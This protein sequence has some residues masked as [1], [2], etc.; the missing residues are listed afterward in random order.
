[1]GVGTK[2]ISSLSLAATGPAT[3]FSVQ[4]K[5][6]IISNRFMDAIHNTAAGTPETTLRRLICDLARGR[7]YKKG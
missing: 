2:G 3:T 5:I 1:M 7:L 4:V 6:K